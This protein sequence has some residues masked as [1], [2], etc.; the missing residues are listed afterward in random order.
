MA[1]AHAARDLAS[2]L[3]LRYC[4]TLAMIDAKKMRR[5]FVGALALAVAAL[6][7]L[8]LAQAL[9]HTHT[10][11]ENEVACQICQAA[12]AGSAPTVGVELL[13]GPIEG[14]EH[15]LPFAVTFHAELFFQDCPSR[16]P[17]TP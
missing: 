1:F 13:P 3:E 17:P 11:G 10:K 9:T 2:N 6:C 12:H 16:A 14:A 7:V 8:V 15:I 5:G 4:V